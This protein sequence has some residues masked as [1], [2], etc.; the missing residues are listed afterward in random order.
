MKFYNNKDDFLIES[1]LKE[2]YFKIHSNSILPSTP[3][4]P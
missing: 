1:L 2:N 3:R 4:P